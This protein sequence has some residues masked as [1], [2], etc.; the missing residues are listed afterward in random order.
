M[1]QKVT[2]S[3][4]DDLITKILNKTQ[5]KNAVDDMIDSSSNV[6]NLVSKDWKQTLENSEIYKLH[7]DKKISYSRNKANDSNFE[8]NTINSMDNCYHILV[9]GCWKFNNVVTKDKGPIASIVCK[10]SLPLVYIGKSMAAHNQQIFVDNCRFFP[11][12]CI[13]ELCSQCALYKVNKHEKSWCILTT[14]VFNGERV[15]HTTQENITNT[16]GPFKFYGILRVDISSRTSYGENKYKIGG[17]CSNMLIFIESALRAP[18]TRDCLC[19]AAE[20]TE[21]LPRITYVDEN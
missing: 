15:L 17:S 21:T 12:P 18:L 9:A 10:S 8:V 1:Y 4:Y 5:L 3:A 19:L 11:E 13:P 2:M 6:L 14:R 16:F 20:P 7:N